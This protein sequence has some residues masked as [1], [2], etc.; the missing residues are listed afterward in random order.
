M[1]VI[2]RAFSY[3]WH[4]KFLM[5]LTIVLVSVLMVVDILPTRVTQTILDDYVSGI[6]KPWYEID[7]DTKNSVEL[8]GHYYV[9][10]SLYKQDATIIQNAC[11][12]EIDRSILFI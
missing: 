1:K 3:A 12:V 11:V 7:H 9:Q 10:S 6:E 2:K 8:D 5:V 4:V